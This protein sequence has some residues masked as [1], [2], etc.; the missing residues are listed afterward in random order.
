ME[1]KTELDIIKEIIHETDS[2]G[3]FNAIA[4]FETFIRLK[5]NESWYKNE[6]TESCQLEDQFL[7]EAIPV[8]IDTIELI[9]SRLPLGEAGI[10]LGRF[11]LGPYMYIH[12]ATK[13]I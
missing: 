13:E 6:I 5:F 8:I 3:L 1:Y 11:N 7:P 2:I 4:E 12:P 9:K 10:L